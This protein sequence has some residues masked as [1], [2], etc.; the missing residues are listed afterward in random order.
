MMTTVGGSWIKAAH[1]QAVLG[2]LTDAGQAAYVVGGC[3]RNDL[4][5]QPVSDIDIATDAE[6]LRVVELAGRAGLKVV[7]TGIDHGTVT[8][9]AEGIPHEVTT[10]RR[11]VET[12]GRRAVVRFSRSLVED[13]S[14]RDFTM[15]ALYADAM[16]RVTDPVGGLADLAQR[17]VRFIGDA[18]ARIREDYLRILRF[19]RFQAWYG[20]AM[21][22]PDADGL[23]ACAALADGVSRLS[24]ERVGHEM[25]KLL[26]APDPAPALASMQAAGVLGQILPGADSRVI[27]PLVH[28]ENG[29]AASWL[30]RLAA[31]GGSDLVNLLRLSRDEAGQMDA[32]T[33]AL[34]ADAEP[35]AL[36]YRYGRSAALAAVLIRAASLGADLPDSLDSRLD[37]GSRA[38]LP[39]TAQ[40]LMPGLSGAA[41]GQALRDVEDRWVASGFSLTRD[42]LLR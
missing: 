16:G 41:L 10:F 23:A 14:R 22:G 1:V 26:S 38:Q 8:V 13:A 39:V 5:G 9:I 19:F 30:R 18:E 6:P 36:A 11:D 3:V 31:L 7:P 37:A 25:R 2:L 40:D 28:L 20:D 12:D 17:K 4:L 15:N 32:I 27:A 21:Q 29:R 33:K 42:D 24:K 34:G 35:E